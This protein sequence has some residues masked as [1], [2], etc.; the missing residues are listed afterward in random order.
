[1][2]WFTASSAQSKASG[3]SKL[4]QALAGMTSK[5]FSSWAPSSKKSTP[6]RNTE[7]ESLDTGERRIEFSEQGADVVPHDLNMYK[8]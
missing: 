2:S 4:R 3:L 1:M 8:Q 5:V 6:S 7:G